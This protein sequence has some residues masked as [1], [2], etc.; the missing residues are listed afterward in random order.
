[1]VVSWVSIYAFWFAVWTFHNVA[2]ARAADAVGSFILYPGRWIFELLGGDQSAIFYDPISFSG[3]NGLVVGIVLYCVFR[4]GVRR[5][6]NGKTVEGTANG[7]RRVEA[8][9]RG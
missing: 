8:K 7:N 1:M 6:E 5:R 3:T 9:A 4:A 2:A